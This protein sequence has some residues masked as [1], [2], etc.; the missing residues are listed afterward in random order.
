MARPGQPQIQVI[1][2]W[3]CVQ[4]FAEQP[5]KLPCRQIRHTGDVG[6]RQ[7]LFQIVLHGFYH[8]QQFR[9]ADAKA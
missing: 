8:G 5:F 3:R 1:A 6:L 7:R 9:V 4:I 2:G